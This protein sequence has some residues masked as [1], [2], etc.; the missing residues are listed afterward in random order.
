MANTFLFLSSKFPFIVSY[1]KLGIAR[2]YAQLSGAGQM[3]CEF[4]YCFFVIAIGDPSLG[5][6]LLKPSV[7]NS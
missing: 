5:R 3:Y 6:S 4:H 7:F 1:R 2:D